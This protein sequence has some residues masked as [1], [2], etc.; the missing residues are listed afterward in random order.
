MSRRPRRNHSP[1]FKAKVAPAAV[2]QGRAAVA[3]SWLGGLRPSES[4]RAEEGPV[5]GG[6]CQNDWRG[7]AGRGIAGP[8]SDASPRVDLGPREH[9]K[10]CHWYRTVPPKQCGSAS[11]ALP[12]PIG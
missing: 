11:K 8:E 6:G 4:D 1:E 12:S 5:A 10:L 3:G 2:C 7:L 9:R